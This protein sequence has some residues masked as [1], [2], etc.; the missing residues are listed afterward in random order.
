MRHHSF[1]APPTLESRLSVEASNLGKESAVC[2][3]TARG[4]ELLV[5]FSLGGGKGREEGILAWTQLIRS[6]GEQE[7][8]T[9]VSTG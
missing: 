2:V 3:C 6:S 7:T 8:L 9:E 5:L 4:R 1:T